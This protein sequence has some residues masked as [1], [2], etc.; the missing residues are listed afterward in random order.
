M[1][2]WILFGAPPKQRTMREMLRGTS[3]PYLTLL[4]MRELNRLYREWGLSRD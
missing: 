1:I 2:D 4:N 3:L